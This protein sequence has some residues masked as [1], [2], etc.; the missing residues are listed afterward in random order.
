MAVISYVWGQ[1]HYPVPYNVARVLGY[2]AGGVFLWWGC[3]QL[4]L[5]GPAKY[6][7]R[8]VVFLGAVG[9]AWKLERSSVQR[10]TDGQAAD[11]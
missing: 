10:T 8:A 5:E 9:Y 4:P 11:L 6:A 2:M 1:K 7:V 3:E